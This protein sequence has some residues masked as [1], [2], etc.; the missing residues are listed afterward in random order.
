MGKNLK[1]GAA[2]LAVLFIAAGTASAQAKKQVEKKITIV[3]VDDKGIKKDTTFIAHDTIDFQ[4]DE[5][6]IETKGGQVWHG[7]GKGEKMIFMDSEAGVPGRPAMEVRQ[8]RNMGIDADAKEGVN[9]HVSV[10]GVI[11]NIR[12]PKEKAKEADLILQ[13]VKKV[14]MK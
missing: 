10:D 8:M 9:Y 12:A 3:T 1:T 7:K 13:E 14:L 2:I 6:V 11:V 4:G 5:I